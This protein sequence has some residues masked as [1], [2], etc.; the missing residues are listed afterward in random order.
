MTV[1]GLARMVRS[2]RTAQ[3]D[4]FKSRLGSAL[5][6]CKR[7]EKEVDEAV[8]AILDPQPDLF[9]PRKKVAGEFQG[10]EGW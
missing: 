5:E 2:L 7:R 8:R 6:D 1:E 9:D 10:G 3:K 4:Y